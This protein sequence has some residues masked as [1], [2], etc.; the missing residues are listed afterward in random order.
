MEA[1]Q[2][3]QDQNVRLTNTDELNSKSQE[4]LQRRLKQLDGSPDALPGSSQ[5]V[6]DGFVESMRKEETARNDD[7]ARLDSLRHEYDR[8]YRQLMKLLEQNRELETQLPQSEPYSTPPDDQQQAAGP[9]L[10]GAVR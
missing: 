4:Q 7:L 5:E 2:N 1:L 8:K 10:P 3:V 9:E 6:I